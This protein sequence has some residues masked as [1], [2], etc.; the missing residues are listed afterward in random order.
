MGCLTAGAGTVS[1][2]LSSYW[3]ASSG[4]DVMVCALSYCTLLCCVWLVSLG[5]LLF[6]EGKQRV[7]GSGKRGCLRGETWRREKGET[8]IGV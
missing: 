1:D 2:S 6:S 8:A 3:V 4:P 5:G 7:D